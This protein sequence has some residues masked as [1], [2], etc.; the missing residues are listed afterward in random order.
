MRIQAHEFQPRDLVAG[1][2][3]L[4]LVNTVTAR[5]AEPI[6]WLD[7][8]SALLAWARLT[9][10]F[11]QRT[12][13]ALEQ[14]SAADPRAAARALRRIRELRET[15]HD[16]AQPIVTG[17]RVQPATL[18]RLDRIWK[19][20]LAHSR[21][22]IAGGHAQPQ[23]TLASSGLDLLTDELA[24]HSVELLRTL[25]LA[26]TRVCPAQRCG[27]LFI[28]SSKGGQRRWCDMATCGNRAKSSRHRNRVR[29]AR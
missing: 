14:A 15:V 21:L 19:N 26:H 23:L 11:D 17:R 1:H 13:R 7:T 9:G 4:D 8:Y 18:D 3:A 2:V 10:E 22:D 24:L 16:V 5:N 25:P 20:A 27:W 12:L 29:R 6:D 28:D